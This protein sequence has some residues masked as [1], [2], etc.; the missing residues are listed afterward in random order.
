MAEV[1][2][3]FH[4]VVAERLIEQL[5]AGTAPWQ[6]PWD[7]G[8]PGAYMPMNPTTG[9]R[10]K[11]I[12]ALQLMAQERN[13]SRWLTYKQ[14]VA[15]GAQ[16]RK[17][18]KG[19]P[20]QYWK[21][22]EEQNKLDDNGRPVKDAQGEPVKVTVMLE[23][24]RVF[25]ATVFNAEQVDGLP[26]MQ[27]KEQTWDAIERAEKIIAASGAVIR[28][29]GGARAFYRSS[30]DDIHLPDRGQF[31][32]AADYYGVKLHELGH[33]TGHGS[34]LD[35]DL[36]HPFGSEEYA[37]EELRAEIASMIIG[38]ELGIGHDP[39]QHAAYVGSWIKALED[40]PLEIFR[41]SSD[42]EKIHDY[43]LAFEQKQ[44]Q[45]QTQEAA[46]NLA[47]VHAVSDPLAVDIAEVLT[48]PD[49]TFD[50]FE[51][52]QGATLDHALR[53]RGLTTVESVTGNDPARFYD[54]AHNRL[55]E[56]FGISPDHTEVD[57]AY[58][59]RKGLAQAFTAKAEAIIQ[60]LKN[61]DQRPP[62]EMTKAEF[63]SQA[64]AEALTNHGRKWNVTLG[65]RFSAFSDADSAAAAVADVHHA[66]VNNALFIN[67]PEA[68]GAGIKSTLPP[69]AVL[70]EYPDLV[71]QYP[72][73]LQQEAKMQ[74]PSRSSDPFSDDNFAAQVGVKRTPPNAA[75]GL[76]LSHVERGTLSATIETA[77][78]E[79][80]DRVL[81]VLDSMQP[82]NTQNA[83]WGRHELPLDA[84]ALN[85]KIDRAIDETLLQRGDA[86]VAAALLDMKTGNTNS[87]ERDLA[88]FDQAA[89]NA[90]G[91]ALPHD[92]TGEVRIVGV[93]ERD[94]QLSAADLA[95]ETPQAFHLYAR[96]GDA[97]PGED[98]FAFLTATT[99]LEDANAMTDRLAV[100]DANSELNES[101]RA[102][103][104][105]RVQEDRVRRDPD[106]TSEEI[107]AAK[108]MR[109]TAD[110][111]VFASDLDQKVDEQER[112]AWAAQAQALGDKA[113]PYRADDP[114]SMDAARSEEMPA[115]Q[116][117][118]AEQEKAYINVPFREKN[119]AKQLGARWDRQQQSWYVPAGVD[120]A[121]FAKWSQASQDK[122]AEASQ[123]A[124]AAQGQQAPA[125]RQPAERQY[126]AVPYG[127]RGAAKAA[128][129][130]W[131]KAA[132]SWYAGPNS[133]MERLA[134]WKPD[135]MPEQGPAMTPKDEFA[136]ALAD[137]GCLVSGDHPIMDGQRHRIA[138]EGDKKG[139]QA[140][141][142]VGHLDGHPA[143]YIKNNRTGLD[144]KWKS[145][146]YALDPEEKAKLHAEAATKLAARAADQDRQHE[147]TA[148]RVAK[149]LA[150]LVP[151]LHDVQF[152]TADPNVV[153]VTHLALTT[154]YMEAKGIQPH[155][156]AYSDKEGKTTYLPAYDVDGKQWTMQYIQE[157]GTKRFAKDSRKEG[158]FHPLGGMDALAAAPVLVIAE[159]YATAGTIAD[160]LG[161][162]TVAAFDSG[163]LPAVA[164]ALHEKF[165]DKP[166]I[167]AGD[168][169]RHQIITQG[170]NPGRTKAEE[171]AKAVGGTAIFPIF[172]PGENVYP[173]ELPPVTPQ[174]Y[175]E[176]ER[177][178]QRLDAAA[179]DPEAVKLTS[180]EAADLKKAL[181]SPEQ[182]A[183]IAGMK[184]HTDFNDLA[185]RSELGR[186]GVKR[187][188]GAAVSQVL[189]AKVQHQEQ[190]KQEVAQKHIQ[191][192]KPRRA[193]KI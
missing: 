181:L 51:A 191:E 165:P 135:N 110:A 115:K 61:A 121:P 160:E 59:E 174:T 166:V 118:P 167:I 192:D 71:A 46:R 23:R 24:P 15:A 124:P 175:R 56:A 40:D 148:E 182:L 169:D 47:E 97:M 38:D 139:E 68:A 178:T 119:E 41:A 66:T 177:A 100:I 75:E 109:L 102:A 9:K 57:N 11:G 5:K 26:P 35:R 34:R 64:T 50:H 186:E 8:E 87:R 94:G 184:A 62:H 14:A 130:L 101:V 125:E 129:A 122:P 76:I 78:L 143:G 12:N 63:A 131:D 21:F 60:E 42:A 67:M 128:G 176:H 152:P 33:W 44:V 163:N 126:L 144:M 89:D 147:A 146:G 111:A 37:K 52:F 189:A 69:P 104:L 120:Q 45:E 138:V 16:V 168:D 140:G 151:V 158:C 145:K 88:A 82:L 132:K 54:E 95:T 123:E 1:K 190:Q 172:A 28:H 65:D 77:S 164:K 86:V 85:D 70:A 72:Q 19:T 53:S 127:E 153:G 170:T 90:L 98:A 79:Q 117:T 185:T 162:A 173:A 7:A 6:R 30:T 149:Q 116:L 84:D 73:A 29:D 83:F 106:S 141:F 13:D 27:R 107:S 39:E 157:D 80:V 99:T 81:G 31:A 17:G 161:H 137:M 25:F 55:S 180:Q 154:K 20:I 103:K 92:W 48:G 58:L 96:K 32:T 74:T 114:A 179:K 134:R 22:S 91:F 49:V 113:A 136:E 159:G 18:E 112:A 188:V 187:Q 193:V 2:K 183:G 4:E 133:D 156:G 108:E 3:P 43:V 93:V 36:G 105:A 150:G 171:A 10:Y 142:Y 155:A